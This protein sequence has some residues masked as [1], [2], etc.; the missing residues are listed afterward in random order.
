MPHSRFNAVFQSQR[1]VLLKIL[2]RMV[3]SRSTAEDLLQETW[4]R[5]TRALN[6]R[7]VE[8]LEPF[9]YQTARNLALDHLRARR[10]RQR[11]LVE[12]V[13]P[14]ELESVAAQLGSPEDCAH[15][16][17]LLDSLGARLGQ[18]SPRQQRIFVLSRLHGCSYQEIA[19][20]LNV[21]PS[22]VQKE[23]KLIMAI[24][25]GVIARLDPA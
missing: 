10:V 13:S 22:T 14:Q 2:Q 9:V 11:T 8:H 3:G 25:I 17:R 18:L 15:A 4:L 19:D 20:A 23:L 1:D 7:G 21:S 12:D 16:R 5:V 24:C 6:E